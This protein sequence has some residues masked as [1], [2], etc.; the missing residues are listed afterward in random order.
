M[1]HEIDVC[2]IRAEDAAKARQDPE[3]PGASSLLG[4]WECKFF[5][6]N[7]DKVLGRAF[8]G[9]L[10]DMG[11]NLRLSGLC[12]NKTHPQLHE[13]LRP[14]RRPYPHLILTPLDHASERRFVTMLSAELKKMSAA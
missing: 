1:M 3:A 5:D 7:L 10:D 8:V 14:V 9:L 6:H 2:I 4:A 11:Q 12:S 13:Y